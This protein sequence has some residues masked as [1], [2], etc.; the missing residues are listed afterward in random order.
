M[1]AYVTQE[2]WFNCF[3]QSSSQLQGFPDGHVGW[4]IGVMWSCWPG[5]WGCSPPAR[6]PQ[7]WAARD[8]SRAEAL[9]QPSP[10]T[11]EGTAAQCSHHV[12]QLGPYRWYRGFREKSLRANVL[13][14]Q[15]REG[16]DE[17]RDTIPAKFLRDHSSC[18]HSP[19][20]QEQAAAV[21]TDLSPATT[22]LNKQE[23][24][25]K[26]INPFSQALLYYLNAFT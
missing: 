2:L 19:P 20:G 8:Q 14:E 6:K 24:V 1:G 3:S 16:L 10:P 26:L 23:T 15:S 7:C 18:T 13:D 17:H 9:S 25:F 22:H 21:C 12:P 11:A 4:E 5:Y